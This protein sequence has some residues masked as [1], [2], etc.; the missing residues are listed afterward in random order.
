MA[1]ALR[2]RKRVKLSKGQLPL[3]V[4]KNFDG[5]AL[6]VGLFDY[7][8]CQR[9]DGSF[10]GTAT[11]NKCRQ[12]TEVSDTDFAKAISVRRKKVEAGR[13]VD[14]LAAAASTDAVTGVT[15]PSK[16]EVAEMKKLVDARAAELQEKMEKEEDMTKELT[17]FIENR[18]FIGDP[19]TSPM[20]V[21]GMEDGFP[22]DLEKEIGYQGFLARTMAKSELK[23][24]YPDKSRAID[25]AQETMG[26]KVPQ[27]YHRHA[28]AL[29]AITGQ[30]VA[31]ED[32]MRP[33]GAIAQ[34]ELRSIPAKGKGASQWD[35]GKEGFVKNNS[36]NAELVGS[37]KVYQDKYNDRMAKNLTKNIA[38]AADKNPNLRSVVLATGKSDPFEAKAAAG[39]SYQLSKRPGAKAREFEYEIDS[40]SGKLRATGSIVDVKGNGKTMVYNYGASA[41]AQQ[42]QGT[43]E[44]RALGAK[45]AEEEMKL[46]SGQTTKITNPGTSTRAPARASNSVPAR[47]S[48]PARKTTSRATSNNKPKATPV[49]TPP[50]KQKSTLTKEQQIAA[51]TNLMKGQGRDQGEINAALKRA[52]L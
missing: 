16:G 50:K 13:S 48:T 20:I 33:N 38:E 8:T 17:N 22:S 11:G 39:T 3:F 51:I 31:P 45:F 34:L 19:L 7:T 27:F 43:R 52:G 37:R 4:E 44:A 1:F 15:L 47:A 9:T 25:Y 49:P 18:K 10:Y 41:S 28:K 40:P 30:T 5:R 14:A 2:R 32:M 24:E 42:L 35:I 26:D 6:L 46:R 36:A 23:Q 12:G 29:S 21:V